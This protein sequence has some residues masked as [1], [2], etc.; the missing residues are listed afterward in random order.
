MHRSHEAEKPTPGQG[1]KTVEVSRYGL[2]AS[3]GRSNHARQL[4]YRGKARV[5]TRLRVF[6]FTLSCYTLTA[7]SA[8]LTAP[9]PAKLLGVRVSV[10]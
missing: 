2:E 9:S 10:V 4:P 7:A 3:Q 1:S 6:V 5:S 8:T